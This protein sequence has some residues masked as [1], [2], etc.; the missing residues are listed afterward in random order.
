MTKGNLNEDRDLPGVIASKYLMS[1][2]D[3]E[4]KQAPQE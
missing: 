1:N 3:S 2:E 4:I